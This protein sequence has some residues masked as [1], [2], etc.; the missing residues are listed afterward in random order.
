MT[1]DEVVEILDA[2]N[3]YSWVRDATR[4]SFVYKPD[5]H[6]RILRCIKGRAEG[7]RLEQQAK[8]PIN[9]NAYSV[10]YEVFYGA[11]FVVEMVLFDDNRVA[12][13]IPEAGTKNVSG[14]MYRFAKIVDTT[15]K[16]DAYV[17]RYGLEVIP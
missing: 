13:P 2:G 17:A 15:G 5:L 9:S 6:L 3:T 7:A 16:L 11:S 8:S 1:F 12:M 10:G 4:G 14:R